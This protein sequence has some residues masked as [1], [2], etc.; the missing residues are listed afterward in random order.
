M[1]I[2]RG[3]SLT[4][5]EQSGARPAAFDG[6]T[7]F[8][9]KTSKASKYFIIGGIIIGVLIVGFILYLITQASGGAKL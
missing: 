6:N 7:S 3:V 9:K 5:L 4:D 8:S 2:P 1:V